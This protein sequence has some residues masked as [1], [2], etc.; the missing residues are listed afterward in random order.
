MNGGKWKN[1]VLLILFVVLCT[2]FITRAAFAQGGAGTV[3]NGGGDIS[4]DNA[5]PLSEAFG[6]ANNT[7]TTIGAWAFNGFTSDFAYEGDSSGYI[8]VSPGSGNHFAEASV[9]LPSGVLLESISLE[10]CD[11]SA[12]NQLRFT[13]YRFGPGENDSTI[14][15]NFLT[16]TSETPGC[17]EFTHDLSTPVTIDNEKY[18]YLA[19]IWDPDDSR[20]TK[21]RA[22]RFYWKRQISP[23][24]E[25]ASFSDV[26]TDYWAFQSIEALVGSGIT[27]GCGSG[28][29]CPE[30][31]VTRAQMAAFLSRALGLNWPN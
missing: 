20:D 21:Y 15:L 3:Y 8:S 19:Q 13:L 2:L 23:P 26:P 9:Y 1:S 22:V 6:T 27:T 31:F 11:N 14:L 17:D 28:I 5:S 25:T 7:I 29:Y 16:G 4:S 10:A 12:S 24:P 18:T 30:D